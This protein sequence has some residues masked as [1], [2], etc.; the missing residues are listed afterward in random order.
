[1]AMLVL[2]DV[3]ERTWGISCKPFWPEAIYKVTGNKQ[4]ILF[5]G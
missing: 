2:P 3:F 5:Y 4:R 1:M